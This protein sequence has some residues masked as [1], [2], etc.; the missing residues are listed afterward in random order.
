M[1]VVPTQKKDGGLKNGGKTEGDNRRKKNCFINNTYFSIKYN[2][3]VFL[4]LTLSVFFLLII[5]LTA[6]F[7][8]AEKK[9]C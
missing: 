4:Y 8:E 3:H 1:S 5:P 7:S 2:L 6:Q 9:M